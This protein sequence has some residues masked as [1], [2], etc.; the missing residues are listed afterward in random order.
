MWCTAICTRP[1][2]AHLGVKE[3]KA[4]HCSRSLWT[5][6]HVPLQ[7]LHWKIYYICSTLLTPSHLDLAMNTSEA[8][9]GMC[10][11]TF[12]LHLA[13][14]KKQHTQHVTPF[15]H[16]YN[17]PDKCFRKVCVRGMKKRWRTICKLSI[18]AGSS[19]QLTAGWGESD[20]DYISQETLSTQL[21]VLTCTFFRSCCKENLLEP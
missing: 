8:P 18:F 9:W 6:Q 3:F 11:I 10:L 5:P 1:M 2:Q 14:N 4:I 13:K 21:L 17:G 19:A 15:C 16:I 12:L 7:V 20:M